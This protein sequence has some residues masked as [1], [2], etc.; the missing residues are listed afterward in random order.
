MED[1]NDETN[2]AWGSN[3]PRQKLSENYFFKK[4]FQYFFKKYFNI[5]VQFEMAMMR[6]ELCWEGVQPAKTTHSG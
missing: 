6:H 5:P 3:V 2:L 1:D 4:R